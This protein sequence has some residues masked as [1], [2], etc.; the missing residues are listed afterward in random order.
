MWIQIQNVFYWHKRSLT[1]QVFDVLKYSSIHPFLDHLLLHVSHAS[2]FLSLHCSLIPMSFHPFIPSS[3]YIFPSVFERWPFL[4]LSVLLSLNPLLS[5]HLF[6]HFPSLSPV[7]PTLCHCV[8]ATLC[9][10]IPTNHHHTVPSFLCLCCAIRQSLCPSV[11]PSMH[12]FHYPFPPAFISV[13]IMT[14][15]AYWASTCLT[16]TSIGAA[17]VGSHQCRMDGLM[18]G[19]DLCQCAWTSPPASWPPTPA[20]HR[21]THLTPSYTHAI[22][23]RKK[24]TFFVLLRAHREH[25]E[26]GGEGQLGSHQDAVV[27]VVHL[28]L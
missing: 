16:S 23:E 20:L 7:A 10:P 14:S 13:R 3:L 6:I 19:D 2:V 28:C 12:P 9:T 25:V 21:L 24:I 15:V 27:V 1:V 11:P 17:A 4:H 18:R 22:R 8:P 5:L 26:V